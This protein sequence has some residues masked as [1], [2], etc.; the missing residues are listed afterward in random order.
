MVPMRIAYFIPGLTLLPL[1]AGCAKD[2][3]MTPPAMTARPPDMTAV[4]DMA[5]QTFQFRFV[6]SEIITP[7]N[8]VAGREYEFDVDGNGSKENRLG[9]VNNVM[10]TAFNQSLQ[11][12]VDMALSGGKVIQLF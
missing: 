1:I 10:A 12:P 9:V 6:A 4:A 11:L 8:K 7:D 2:P 5:V 3:Q